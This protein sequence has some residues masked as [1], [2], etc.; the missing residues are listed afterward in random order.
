[1]T[2]KK[3]GKSKNRGLG[4]RKSLFLYLD[5]RE[6][7]LEAVSH[8][9]QHYSVQETVYILKHGQKLTHKNAVLNFALFQS[10]RAEKEVI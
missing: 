1:V 6:E 5:Y 2:L 9:K 8:R 3:S 7:F 4:S 10:R